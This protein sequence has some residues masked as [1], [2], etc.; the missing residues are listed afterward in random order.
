MRTRTTKKSSDSSQTP[1]AETEHRRSVDLRVGDSFTATSGR[2]VYPYK[3]GEFE[4]G[5]V[6][7]T[8]V[9][10]EGE[11]AEALVQRAWEALWVVHTAAFNLKFEEYKERLKV[12][13]ED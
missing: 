11:D 5:S 9:L 13:C 8:L 7:V 6:S 4:L 1:E 10:H 2:E 3:D 12:V